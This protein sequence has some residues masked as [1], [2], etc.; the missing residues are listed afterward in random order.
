MFYN[1]PFIIVNEL[2]SN[3]LS[4]NNENNK[5]VIFYTVSTTF[6]LIRF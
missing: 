6:N 4:I 2:T 5:R 3:N 1:M